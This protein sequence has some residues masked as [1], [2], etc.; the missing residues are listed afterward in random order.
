MEFNEFDD[1]PNGSL[2]ATLESVLGVK[3]Q[4]RDSVISKFLDC[5]EEDFKFDNITGRKR[6]GLEEIERAV[7]TYYAKKQEPF[8]VGITGE[9]ITMYNKRKSHAINMI[10]VTY[11]DSRTEVSVFRYGSP[12]ENGNDSRSRAF[13]A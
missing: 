9:K 1:K 13:A 2:A 4:P 12:R 10:N 7:Y 3:T 6:V 5:V 11:M 8:T